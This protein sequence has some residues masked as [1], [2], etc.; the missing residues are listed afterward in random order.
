MFELSFSKRAIAGDFHGEFTLL[1][2]R[3]LICHSG[4]QSAGRVSEYEFTEVSLI[5]TVFHD[6]DELQRHLNCVLLILQG[7]FAQLK[8][9]FRF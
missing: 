8:V 1:Q 6:D 5:V 3:F 4:E 7:P 9:V 2:Q